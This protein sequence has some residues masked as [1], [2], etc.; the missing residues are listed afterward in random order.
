MHGRDGRQ[1]PAQVNPAHQ[2]FRNSVSRCMAFSDGGRIPRSV[3]WIEQHVTTALESQ[4][5]QEVLGCLIEDPERRF[6][7][8][9]DGGVTLARPRALSS[10]QSR[11][12]NQIFETAHG[13]K[14]FLRENPAVRVGCELRGQFAAE[15]E[16]WKQQHIGHWRGGPSSILFLFSRLGW[17]QIREGEYVVFSK[18][19][20]TGRADADQEFPTRSFEDIRQGWTARESNQ[21]GVNIDRIAWD[22][23]LDGSERILSQGQEIQQLVQ[24]QNSS[25]E[26]K[27]FDSVTLSQNPQDAFAVEPDCLLP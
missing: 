4:S 21:F 24:I 16:S 13:F 6:A 20:L 25:K 26:P 11:R 9:R 10:S 23:N 3:S 1:I 19:F 12:N 7:F 17:A 8:G 2:E 18:A 22:C 15:L 27:T 5:D 14:C